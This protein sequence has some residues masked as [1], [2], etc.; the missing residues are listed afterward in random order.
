MHILWLAIL[1]AIPACT[2]REANTTDRTVT[3][4]P[5][6]VVTPVNPPP[7]SQ[8][9]DCSPP[10]RGA[11]GGGK[12]EGEASFAKM[13][14]APNRSRRLDQVGFPSFDPSSLG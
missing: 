12:A 4:L 13:K 2:S 1:L 11:V 8:P 3:P 7:A 6:Q 5:P 14:G 10:S 9:R